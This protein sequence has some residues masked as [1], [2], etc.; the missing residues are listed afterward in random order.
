[1]CKIRRIKIEA[2]Y[3]R[4]PRCPAIGIAYPLASRIS[5]DNRAAFGDENDLFGGIGRNG[6]VKMKPNEFVKGRLLPHT[7]SY[8]FLAKKV[9]NLR[10]DEFISGH[11]DV[12]GRQVAN[13]LLHAI[14]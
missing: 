4:L 13:A 12:T 7:S 14:G 8:Q 9:H 5:V 11:N 1:M 3:E 6:A 10:A 2:I